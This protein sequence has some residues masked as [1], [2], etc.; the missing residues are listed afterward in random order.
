MKTFSLEKILIFIFFQGRS[1]LYFTEETLGMDPLG[2]HVPTFSGT[3]LVW[4]CP[5][6]SF[7]F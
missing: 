4:M 5:H 2:Q 3:H 7:S 6:I 1:K